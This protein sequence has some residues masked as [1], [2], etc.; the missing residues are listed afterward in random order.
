MEKKKSILGSFIAKVIGLLALCIL[1]SSIVWNV[2]GIAYISVNEYPDGLGNYYETND[3]ENNIKS[4]LGSVLLDYY[5]YDN[6]YV[7]DY[8]TTNSNVEFTIAEYDQNTEKY[9]TV[10]QKIDSTSDHTESNDYYY[11]I[12]KTSDEY[13]NYEISPSE[14]D[15]IDQVDDDHML[16]RISA[17]LLSPLVVHDDFYQNTKYFDAFYAKAN[18]LYPKVAVEIVLFLFVLIFEFSAAGHK[19]NVEGIHTLW[20]DKI[21]FE[22]ICA[23]FAIA[24]YFMVIGYAAFINLYRNFIAFDSIYILIA[25]MLSI[26]LNIYLILMTSARKIKAGI[27][28]QTTI[29]HFVWSYFVSFLNAMAFN[30]KATIVL[31]LFLLL[32]IDLLNSARYQLTYEERLFFGF[33]ILLQYVISIMWIAGCKKVFTASKELASGDRNYRITEKEMKYM[34]HSLKEQ[35]NNLNEIG[36]GISKAVDKEMKSERLKTEL[37]TNV[38]HDIKTPLTSIINYIDLLEKDPT[39]EEQKQYLEV[40]DRQSSKL[41]KLIE[42]L[43]EASKASTGNISTNITPVNVKELL[44]QSIA[45]YADKTSEA[46]L[47]VVLN[48]KEEP[49][50]VEADG[51]LLWRV[52]SNLFSNATKYALAGTRVYLDAERV[53]D[54][55]VCISM[56]NV[57]RDSL[58]ISPEELTE[59]FV[60]GDESRH[61]EGSGLGLNIAKSLTEIQKGRFELSIDGDLFKASI[62]LPEHKKD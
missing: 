35:A 4:V 21:P 52:L 6:N 18:T 10:L 54:N 55:E 61:T 14:K 26:S 2:I 15:L 40:L 33:I 9:T 50:S 23:Y 27:F 3:C 47:E 25:L 34:S 59:R 45:E 7:S 29:F 57:S 56:K 17:S 20:I 60:R 13:L 51:R 12:D 48:V 44:E 53:N 28:F 38:S 30:W 16:V 42:D 36:Q 49:I 41:K 11:L 37:I 1:G 8:Y 22:I 31:S 39:E 43:V 24:T 19:N 46:N 5:Y 58:N 62:Y 32:E